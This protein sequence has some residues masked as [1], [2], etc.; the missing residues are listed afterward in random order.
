MQK[1]KIV[2]FLII[3]FLFFGQK[4]ENRL[5]LVIGNSNY[6]KGELKNPVNDASLIA[7][8]LDSIGFEVLLYKNLE[9]RRDFLNALY[10]FESKILD[11]DTSFIYYAGHGVQ[12]NN[13]NFLLPTK[14]AFEKELDV[15]DYG[16]SVQRILKLIESKEGKKVNIL[17]IDAC[18]DNPFESN[19]NSTRS[20]KGS[21][22]AKINPPTG[23]IIAF[24]TDSGNTAP[25]GEGGNSIYS[26]SLSKNLFK[27][28]ISIEQ[29]FKNVRQ[30][31]LERSNGLQK[32]IEN[33]TLIGDAFIINKTEV[34][35]LKDKLYHYWREKVDYQGYDFN[36][37]E[38]I[39]L[40]EMLRKLAFYN[41]DD[42]YLLWFEIMIGLSS[43]NPNFKLIDKNFEL[44][45]FDSDPEK[46]NYFKY[47]KF[48]RYIKEFNLKSSDYSDEYL[49]KN[50]KDATNLFTELVE[51]NSEDIFHF[52][53]LNEDADYFYSAYVNPA[54]LSS[55]LYKNKEYKESHKILELRKKFLEDI[56]NKNKDFFDKD[57]FKKNFTT[58]ALAFTEN[59]LILT[60]EK[61]G[62]PTDEITIGWRNLYKKFK[63]NTNLL[64]D[65]VYKV[66]SLYEYDLATTLIN[67]TISLLPED[68]EPYFL[69]YNINMDKKDYS[70]ALMNINFAIERY[71]DGY[72][73]SDMIKKI[74][75]EVLSMGGYD[76]IE[77]KQIMA[78]ELIILKAELLEK[79]NN[80]LM[81][82]EEYKRAIEALKELEENEK[83]EKYSKILAEKCK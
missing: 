48:R 29:V 53:E 45:S 58:N 30:D 51:I 75:P 31:V 50:A 80:N 17:V 67:K 13:E 24:S 19:W 7:S 35:I 27:G 59:S 82:C 18:R 39:E 37:E 79:L 61:L 11:Y 22:L 28:G 44:L 64:I 25:D 46:N 70:S 77:Q 3:P 23:S 73:I 20:L 32:P 49:L 62:Y 14:E 1:L 42:D 71:K 33:N 83:A 56:L 12:I 57:P 38:I 60:K 65:R 40:N 81:M 34:S 74:G 76:V 69:L 66:L 41:K 78:W 43:D 36:N 26:E 63:N 72:Y 55:F 6:G 10:E 2:F 9:T 8:T 21:G 4:E 5:A 68:P 52:K 15:L 16:V 47:L 54:F